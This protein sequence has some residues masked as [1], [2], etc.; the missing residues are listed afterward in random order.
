MYYS[1]EYIKIKIKVSFKLGINQKVK[2]D[3]MYLTTDEFIT[4]YS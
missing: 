1:K 4:G 3:T 2:V